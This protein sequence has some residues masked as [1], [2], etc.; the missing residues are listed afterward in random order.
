MY[1]ET[2]LLPIYKRHPS[3]T[4]FLVFITSKLCNFRE[5][6]KKNPEAEI[7]SSGSFGFL[8]FKPGERNVSTF[9]QM[10]C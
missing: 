1:D 8:N 9:F 7:S 10:V 5:K 2:S 4:A 3:S 6:T